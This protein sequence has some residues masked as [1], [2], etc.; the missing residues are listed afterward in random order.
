MADLDIDSLLDASLAVREKLPDD[1]KVPEEIGK[2]PEDSSAADGQSEKKRTRRSSRSRSRSRSRRRRRRSRSRSPRWNRDRERSPPRWNRERSPPRWNRDRERSPPRW[3]RDRS[4]G[5]NRDRS[6]A[7]GRERD[8]AIEPLTQ[9]EM[10]AQ[11]LD[12]QRRTL[13]IARVAP[14]ATEDDIRALFREAKIDIL[15]VRL[16]IDR[17]TRKSKGVGFVELKSF[18][19]V[20]LALGLSGKTVCSMPILIQITP[21]N[22]EA[23]TTTTAAIMPGTNAIITAPATNPSYTYATAA[24]KRRIYVGSLLPQV[25]ETEIRALLERFGPL[26]FIDMQLDPITRNHRGY[27]FAQFISTDDATRA[28]DELPGSSI[29][30]RAIKLGWGQDNG[31]G[32]FTTSGPKPVVP[33][34]LPAMLPFMAAG[35]VPGANPAAAAAVASMYAAAAAAAAAASGAQLPVQMPVVV[36]PPPVVLPTPVEKLEDDAR[37]GMNLTPAARQALMAKLA[38]TDQP[39]S[40]GAAAAAGAA[41]S[42]PPAF[43]S[44]AVAGRSP[45][46]SRCILLENMFNPATETDPEFHLSIRDD[47]AE[48]CAKFGKVLELRVHRTSP[49]GLV[50]VKMESIRAAQNVAQMLNGR[51][52]AGM[53]VVVAHLLESFFDKYIAENIPA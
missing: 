52:F 44:P 9:E 51:Y 15:D 13:T 25:T 4:P 16:I 27:C 47:V 23:K 45:I 39:V 53:Q 12:K 7:R 18:D 3:N 19:Q 32:G 49:L 42:I 8:E 21:L 29:M 2:I 28:M 11:Q 35:M 50:F 17:M 22:V 1:V 26:E 46:P 31:K 43:V 24:E 10:E 40:G 14:R 41:A 36:A 20:P 48:E 37:S 34:V 38:R 5:R 30:G 6:P 33:A